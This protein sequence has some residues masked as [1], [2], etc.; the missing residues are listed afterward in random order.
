MDA[1]IE[2]PWLEVEAG[3]NEQDAILFEEYVEEVMETRSL[4]QA[5]VSQI[6][7]VQSVCDSHGASIQF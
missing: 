7:H 4:E 3:A 2:Q 6:V 1:N 5:I